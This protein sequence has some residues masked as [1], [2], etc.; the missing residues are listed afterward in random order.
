M[1]VAAAT[2]VIAPAAFLAAP[3][4]YA[5]EGA[6]DT[7]RPTLTTSDDENPPPLGDGEVVPPPAEGE[8][9][10][11]PGDGEA[12]GE[13]PGDTPGGGDGDGDGD[14]T[15]EP[16]PG[17]GEAVQ[18]P[19]GDG[20][21]N[22]PPGDGEIEPPGDGEEEPPGPPPGDGD[23][24]G[25]EEP[26]PPDE[27]CVEG[28]FN[29]SLSG[30]PS[31]IVA[32]SGWEEFSLN[33]DNTNGDDVATIELGAVVLYREDIQDSFE[34]SLTSTYARFEYFDGAKWVNDEHTDGGSV[35]G[36]VDVAA[37]ERFALKLRLK[38]AAKAPA[39][40]AV[41]IAFAISVDDD[42]NCY[43]DEKWYS[44]D[45]LAADSTPGTVPPAKPEDGKSPADIKPQGGAKALP[46]AANGNLAETG[47]SS[48][49]PAIGMAAGLAV[50]VGGGV[51]F[52]L[53]RRDGDAAA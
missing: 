18:P 40:S 27:E 29:T 26:T 36:E 16:P 9:E 13:A 24:D 8:I 23:G 45:V 42:F 34:S 15:V 43:F 5:A 21:V 39:G 53:R 3:A 37:G 48:M 6:T 46:A 28:G 2:A 12:P 19:P 32:G 20:A 49:L 38:I 52:A 47:S 25:E 22:P 33:L 51:V 31:K 17:N 35:A 10:P 41:A 30:L 7:V 1:A 44:F 11:P 4:V 14:G 50:V